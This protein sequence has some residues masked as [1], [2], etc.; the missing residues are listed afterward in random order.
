MAKA[1][2]EAILIFITS[3]ILL[4]L[5][6][7]MCVESKTGNVVAGLIQITCILSFLLALA[8]FLINAPF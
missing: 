8:H 3:L 4:F 7:G 1:V 6:F 2:G 5:F